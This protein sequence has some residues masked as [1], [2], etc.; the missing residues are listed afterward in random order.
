MVRLKLL[1]MLLVS[2]GISAFCSAITGMSW[3]VYRGR[4]AALPAD[5]YEFLVLEE[6]LKVLTLSTYPLLLL[7]AP[8]YFGIF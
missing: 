5:S 1:F 7:N 4:D 3:V 2:T 8:S 6:N